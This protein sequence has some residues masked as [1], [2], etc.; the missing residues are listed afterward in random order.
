MVQ[1][2]HCVLKKKRLLEYYVSFNFTDRDKIR[3]TGMPRAKLNMGRVEMKVGSE[4][5]TVCVSDDK[6]A[7]VV[8]R[9]LGFSR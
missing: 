4:W 7:R 9:E 1:T 8:C 3:L 5:Q 6:T 2:L